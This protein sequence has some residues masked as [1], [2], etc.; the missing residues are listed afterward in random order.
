MMEQDIK[1]HDITMIELMSS[2]ITRKERISIMVI[3]KNITKTKD[4]IS[5]NYYPEGNMNEEGFMKMG[6]PDKKIIAHKKAVECS[7]A[8]VHVMYE[9]R[10][11]IDL[12][13]DDFP[14][15]ITVLWY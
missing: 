8:P 9:L 15:E 5:A 1:L 14:K 3:L 2:T 11:I 10:D 12:G 7:T 4:S 6:I 13:R